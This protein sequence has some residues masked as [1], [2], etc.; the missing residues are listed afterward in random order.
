MSERLKVYFACA[1]R[2]EQGGKE[3]KK[4]VVDVLKDLGHEVLSEMFAELDINNN[5]LRT[6]TP[7]QIYQQD[8]GW[9]GAS[10]IV[11]A[12]VSRI[13]MGSVMR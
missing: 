12:D 13:S 3:E 1:I 2:G 5:Q 11:V 6:M 8:M 7:E 10:D 4:L 9:L